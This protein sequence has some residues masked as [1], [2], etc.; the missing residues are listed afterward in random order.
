MLITDLNDLPYDE[1][2]A[3]SAISIRKKVYGAG[4]RRFGEKWIELPI[5]KIFDYTPVRQKKKIKKAEIKVKKEKVNYD[6]ICRLNKRHEIKGSRPSLPGEKTEICLF[7]LEEVPLIDRGV[8]VHARFDDN[9]DYGA[10]IQNVKC[11]EFDCLTY[12]IVFKEGVMI[13]Q[14]NKEHVNGVRYWSGHHGLCDAPG[15]NGQFNITHKSILSHE[16]T[17][18][19][20]FATWDYWA[21]ICK[22]I[23]DKAIVYQV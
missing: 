1:P 21:K 14:A 9:I 8:S 5:C 11:D 7:D 6:A 4:N 3:S 12:T 20:G 15:K 10:N 2:R 17:F 16:S 13:F 18:F 22:T 23:R 19:Y